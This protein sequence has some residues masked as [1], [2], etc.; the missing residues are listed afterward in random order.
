MIRLPWVKTV[1]LDD[2]WSIPCQICEGSNSN[3]SRY[4]C[5]WCYEAEFAN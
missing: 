1:R 2:P 3:S 4:V 5:D